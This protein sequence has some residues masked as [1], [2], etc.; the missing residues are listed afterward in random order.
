MFWFYC[1]YPIGV[2]KHIQAYDLFIRFHMGIF[3]RLGILKTI[4]AS[5]CFKFKKVISVQN[6]QTELIFKDF[7][8][9][10]DRS[11]SFLTL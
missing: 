6:V 11:P 10:D 2:F 8:Q 7:K 9:S 4:N 3:L 1:N 5:I